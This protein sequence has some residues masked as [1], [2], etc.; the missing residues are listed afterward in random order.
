MGILFPSLVMEDLD[1]HFKKIH[2]S[3]YFFKISFLKY[4]KKCIKMNLIS[5]LSF[6]TYL[7]E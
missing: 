4:I 5:I 2:N 7:S 6:D 1:L 3:Y